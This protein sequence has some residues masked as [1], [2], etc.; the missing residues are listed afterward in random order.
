MQDQTAL[1]EWR[2]DF[3]VGLVGTLP[4]EALQAAPLDDID[5]GSG[6]YPIHVTEHEWLNNLAQQCLWHSHLF[7]GRSQCQGEQVAR[8]EDLNT[9]LL[10]A[11]TFAKNYSDSQEPFEAL[12]L[13]I[14]ALKRNRWAFEFLRPDQ[15]VTVSSARK[16]SSSLGLDYLP[17]FDATQEQFRA[18]PGF[19]FFLNSTVFDF[20]KDGIE[21]LCNVNLID[22]P[23]GTGKT[24]MA[25]VAGCGHLSVSNDPVPFAPKR[26]VVFVRTRSQTQ[27]F[28]KESKRLGL[29]VAC[30]ISTSLGCQAHDKMT[31]EFLRNMVSTFRW[32][33]AVAK[34]DTSD[35]GKFHV[36]LPK[37]AYP[38]ELFE[39][40][41]NTMEVGQAFATAVSH[42]R[43]YT[44]DVPSDEAF[45]KRWSADVKAAATPEVAHLKDYVTIFD[46]D[47]EYQGLVDYLTSDKKCGNCPANPAFLATQGIPT[48]VLDADR[49]RYG[50][51]GN[52]VT[53]L[54]ESMDKNADINQL[55]EGFQRK[56]GMCGRP[57]SKDNMNGADVVI[58]T[59]NWLT[60]PMIA[61]HAHEALGVSPHELNLKV[62]AV[63]D[64]AHYLYDFDKA[65][66]ISAAD[67]LQQGS[68]LWRLRSQH[69]DQ[70]ALKLPG[71]DAEVMNPNL[72]KRGYKKIDCPEDLNE[73]HM[74]WHACDE[75]FRS[76]AQILDRLIENDIPNQTPQLLLEIATGR[77]NDW[78]PKALYE[79]FD[80]AFDYLERVKDPITVTYNSLQRSVE[81]IRN[82][83][84]FFREESKR[85]ET[86]INDLF[87]EDVKVKFSNDGDLG[88][89]KYAPE[90]KP[91]T[92]GWVRDTFDLWKAGGS[93]SKLQFRRHLQREAC[94]PYDTIVSALSLLESLVLTLREVVYAV[95]TNQ[96]DDRP[97]YVSFEQGS[98]FVRIPFMSWLDQTT[99]DKV[100][101][102]TLAPKMRDYLEFMQRQFEPMETKE[103]AT[104][105]RL[106]VE[107]L[108]RILGSS[109]PTYLRSLA[110]KKEPRSDKNNAQRV[111]C[112]GFKANRPQVQTALRPF[113]HI[114]FL[115]GTPAEPML[116]R[117]K[118]GF[119]YFA[120]SE[121][122]EKPNNFELI[123]DTRFEL[124]MANRSEQLYRQI[125][126]YIPEHCGIEAT[127]VC[128]PSKAQMKV[129]TDQ[130]DPKWL[131]KQL[132]E[133]NEVQLDDVFRYV[134]ENPTGS[135]HVVCGGR[136]VE[137]VEITDENGSSL[138]K[139]I[140][141]V[142][143]P[144][145]PP[146]EKGQQAENFFVRKFQF[147]E[148]TAKSKFMYQPLK[149][150]ILQAKGRCVRNLTDKGRLVLMDFRYKNGKMLRRELNLF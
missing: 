13:G 98:T 24:R 144:F 99:V 92:K 123:Y 104:F 102:N 26:V 106:P 117:Y 5:P 77:Q 42:F 87:K 140:V 69:L 82:S 3:L 2:L 55:A 116:W 1:T 29:S 30:P 131:D 46:I 44:R 73:I 111:L 63:C 31:G 83:V 17:V 65:Q 37:S 22:A 49:E 47:V 21:G 126:S 39:S 64:E 100:E 148:W 105:R 11:A 41:A 6:K 122:P 141:I 132:M 145:N 80:P 95:G 88:D 15:V 36:G 91:R 107:E 50:Q 146:T 16:N 68:E 54:K 149:S 20:K 38:V 23:T 120:T 57:R 53:Y 58:L 4:E 59:Y 147:D 28:L 18:V 115:T 129:I 35:P 89:F 45:K 33:R 85:F 74:A 114:N 112:I 128:Y 62:S 8:W 109:L 127:L 90:D 125:A 136:F 76:A 139:R 40:V 113:A 97:M 86:Q 19:E 94:G 56:F 70:S 108:V 130:M 25:L 101:Q 14:E 66:E 27:A 137:G 34:N 93:R 138:V 43:D 32:M 121:Y 7:P 75:G 133:S 110:G 134:S 9:K 67:I 96:F 135:V 150:K 142:G 71:I 119:R 48:A 84:E 118:S 81:T 51:G 12:L 78:Y 60:D 124:K 79:A 72:R 10:R 103:R 61:Q 52:T 143:V